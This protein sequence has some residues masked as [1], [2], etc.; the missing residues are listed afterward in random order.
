[1]GCLFIGD[2]ATDNWGEIASVYGVTVTYYPVVLSGYATATQTRTPSEGS[3]V[4]VAGIFGEIQINAPENAISYAT[5][6]TMSSGSLTI[7][8]SPGD[9]IIADSQS[10][11]V[12]EVRKMMLGAS[13]ANYLLVLEQ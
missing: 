5:T 9:R 1:M 12:I 13:L 7:T 3:P 6:F 10:Y 11:R 2:L 8:P 4:S